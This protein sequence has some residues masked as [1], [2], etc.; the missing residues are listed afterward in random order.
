MSQGIMTII[1]PVRDLARAKALY[2]TFLGTEPYVDTP[3]YVGFRIGDQ[4]IGL[5][6]HGDGIGAIGYRHVDDIEASLR[7]LLDAGAQVRQGVGDVGGG[8]LIATVGDL[9]G[10]TVGLVQEPAG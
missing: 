9:E 5:D 8:K 3:Y 6:P 10:N 4:E 1:Y 7:S 2:T